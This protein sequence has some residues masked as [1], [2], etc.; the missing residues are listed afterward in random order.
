MRILLLFLLAVI[1]SSP[2]WSSSDVKGWVF[3][4][5]NKKK[6]HTLAFCEASTTYRGGHKIILL[7]WPSSDIS[8]VYEASKRFRKGKKYYTSIRIGK[9]L[10]LKGYGIGGARGSLLLDLPPTS[11]AYL[12][13][14]NGRFIQIQTPLTRPKRYSLIGS[15][16]ALLKLVEC[17]NSRKTKSSAPKPPERKWLTLKQTTAALSD[18]FRTAGQTGH[19]I[20]PTKPKHMFVEF[21]TI[22]GSNGMFQ[23]YRDVL[24]PTYPDRRI[25]RIISAY[26]ERCKNKFLSGKENVPSTDGSLIRKATTKCEMQNDYIITEDLI[27]QKP[28]GFVV[29]ITFVYVSYPDSIPKPDSSIR[30]G[31]IIDAVLKLKSLK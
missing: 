24:D 17:V 31:A 13:L 29:E 26:S 6:D 9:K 11:E 19:T 5:Y 7:M 25:T 22:D 10:V 3:N 15:A 14:Y 20:L 12:S 16:A 23:A 21:E 30:D 2:A 8:I 28:N 27:I 18:I 4:S 1:Y